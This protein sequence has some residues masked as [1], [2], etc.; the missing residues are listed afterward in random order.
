MKGIPG[1]RAGDDKKWGPVISMSAY[2]LPTDKDEL[3]KLI[4]SIRPDYICELHQDVEEDFV[5]YVKGSEP[6]A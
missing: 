5:C 1:G 3:P 4:R 2:H 6:R